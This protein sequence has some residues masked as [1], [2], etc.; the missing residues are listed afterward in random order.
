MSGIA[1][2]D[3]NET[4]LDLAPVRAAID[5]LVAP[6]GG[7][8]VWFQRLL[9]LSMTTTTVGDYQDFSALAQH[10]MHAVAATG[11][12]TL[13]DDAWAQVGAAFG[14]LQAHDDV[15]AGLTTMREAGWATVALTNSAPAAVQGQLEGA[16]LAPLFDHILSV[17]AAGAYKPSAAPYRFAAEAM[18]ADPADLWMVACHDWDLAGARA[19]GYKT[20]FIERPAMSYADA[21]P[22]AEPSN[23]PYQRDW[24]SL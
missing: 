9:Q 12:R 7:F 5:D 10:A 17:E 23:T 4:T 6:E 22:P 20:A 11:G 24:P 3:I 21:F 18:G 16:G 14:Q 15:V 19:V 8:T 13:G 2:F 1:V